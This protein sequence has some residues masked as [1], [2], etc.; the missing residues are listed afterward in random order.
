MP[1]SFGMRNRMNLPW[2][3]DRY[4]VD[5]LIIGSRSLSSDLVLE[6]LKSIIFRMSSSPINSH[7]SLPA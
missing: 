2:Q 3:N 1:N 6:V 5:G 4:G 7:G